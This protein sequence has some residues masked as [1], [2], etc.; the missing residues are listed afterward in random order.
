ML[1]KAN[2]K[3]TFDIIEE[4]ERLEKLELISN[5]IEFIPPGLNKLINLKHLVLTCTRLKEIP[6]ELYSLKNL[7]FLK[8]QKGLF[9]SFPVMESTCFPNLRSLYLNGNKIK[10]L[11]SWAFHLESLEELVISNNSISSL[12]KSLTNLRNLKRL[13]LENNPICEFNFKASDFPKLLSFSID[14]TN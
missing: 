11:P 12:P 3:F 6:Q 10:N 9:E 1:V 7:G 5:S 14:P 8:I 4:P 2:K 13:Y